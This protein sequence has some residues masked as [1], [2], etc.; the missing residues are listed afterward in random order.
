MR[1]IAFIGLGVL[2]A[3]GCGGGEPRENLAR[4]PVPITMTAAI[5]DDVVRVSPASVGAGPIRLVISNQSDRP[6]TV[7]FETDELGG[8]MGGVRAT[9]RKIV[10]HGTGGLTIDARRGTYSVHVGDR[11]IRPARVE[12]GPPRPSAQNRVLLP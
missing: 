7:T 5:Q 4:P 11:A 6:Q 2:A 1:R 12:V 9:S 8:K 10:A 3:A